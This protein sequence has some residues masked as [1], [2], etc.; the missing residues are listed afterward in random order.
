MGGEALI[1]TSTRTGGT[2]RRS[3]Y[4]L[5]GPPPRAFRVSAC[6]VALGAS[7][8]LAGAGAAVAQ[9]SPSARLELQESG[10]EVLLQAVSPVSDL[11]VLF[12][13]SADTTN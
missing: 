12:R 2:R 8:I 1:R 4:A 6:R 3:G 10:V 13:W 11:I 9:E 5:G 7:A